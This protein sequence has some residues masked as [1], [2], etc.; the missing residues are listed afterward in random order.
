MIADHPSDVFHGLDLR[1]HDVAAPLFEHLAHDVDLL[2]IEDLAQVFPV[3]PG[4]RRAFGRQ[5]SEQGVEVGAAGVAETVTV[6]EQ[7]P[8]QPL[9]LGIAFLLGAA[10]EIQGM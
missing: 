8:A 3:L 2:A 7:R 9:E 4:P 10:R 1:A 5:M 6:L